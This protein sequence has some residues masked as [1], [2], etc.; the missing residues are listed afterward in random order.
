MMTGDMT[1]IL[2]G[3]TMPHKYLFQPLRHAN[4][5]GSVFLQ[6]AA[7]K[8]LRNFQAYQ[9]KSICAGTMKLGQLLCQTHTNTQKK[10]QVAAIFRDNAILIFIMVNFC[11]SKLYCSCI[12]WK[13]CLGREPKGKASFPGSTSSPRHYSMRRNYRQGCIFRGRV[14]GAVFTSFSL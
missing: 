12:E 6:Y 7:S 8:Q 14:Y 1:S 4:I 13:S 3:S 2:G 5:F 11:E 9:T 10:F